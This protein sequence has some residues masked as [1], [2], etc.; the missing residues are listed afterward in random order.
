MPTNAPM[1]EDNTPAGILTNITTPNTFNGE[2][3][4]QQQQKQQKTTPMQQEVYSPAESIG[5]DHSHASNRSNHD[6]VDNPSNLATDSVAMQSSP[7]STTFMNVQVKAEP[8][9]WLN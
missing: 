5:S 3:S 6:S 4:Q 2:Q 9:Q 8:G 1:F 7:D